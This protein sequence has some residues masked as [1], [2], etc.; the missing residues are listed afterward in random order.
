MLWTEWNATNLQRRGQ[1]VWQRAQPEPEKMARWYGKDSAPEG[2]HKETS[3]VTLWLDHQLA[4]FD[5]SSTS[6]A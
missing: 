2:Y 6:A 5:I 1:Q 4:E 3:D